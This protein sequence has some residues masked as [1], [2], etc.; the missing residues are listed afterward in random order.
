MASKRQR[1]SKKTSIVPPEE[2][3]TNKF[4]N[5]RASKSY[6]SLVK[7]KKFIKEKG[8]EHLEDF[9]KKDIANKGWKELC[10]PTILT[11]MAVVREFYANLR[12][13]VLKKVWVR[14]KCVAFDSETINRF[15]NLPHVDNESYQ[16]ILE[17]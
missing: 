9:F 6:T 3:D 8:F 2:Y 10:Q 1:V 12:E 17:K 14:G 11:L 15:Y 5:L 16:K 7:R 4:V 13:Q